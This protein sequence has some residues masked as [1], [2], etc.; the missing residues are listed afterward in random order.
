MTSKQLE[1]EQSADGLFKGALQAHDDPRLVAALRAAGF[2]LEQKLAPAYP[3]EDF[4]QWLRIAARVRFPELDEDEGCREIGKLAV[5]R[6]MGSTLL[7]RAVMKAM[8]LLG[9]RRALLRI[10]RSMR[11]G[12]N[13]LEAQARELSPTS[14]EI[15]LGPLVGPPTYYEGVLEEGP[16]QLGARD[17][18]VSRSGGE[19]QQFTWRVD[20]TE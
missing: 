10:G 12:N 1:F 2:D 15:T 16:R 11:N 20:W 4:Y 17:V 9:V 7:G 6:G 13:Y 5:I 19:G 14:V 3:A 8:Q 18:R